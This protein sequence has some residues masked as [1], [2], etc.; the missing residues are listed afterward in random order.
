MMARLLALAGLALAAAGCTPF[1]ELDAQITDKA[2][3][4][5][6]MSLTRIEPLLA[7][8]EK[9]ELTAASEEALSAEGTR[10][11][12][13]GGALLGGPD[14]VE[15][16]RASRERA[17]RAIA[18]A[19]LARIRLDQERRSADVTDLMRAEDV[20]EAV[21]AVDPDL[22][23]EAR[24]EALQARIETLRARTK[25]LREDAR[26]EDEDGLLLLRSRRGAED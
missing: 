13:R 3:S 5:E 4:A 18:E 20:E 2:R 25:R 9:G 21:A 19:A 10:L 1:P 17:E 26:A 8:R 24:A 12:V 22:E 16:A 14:A 6:Y 7:E 23:G 15:T 11:A